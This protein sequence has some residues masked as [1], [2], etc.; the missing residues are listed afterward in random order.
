MLGAE[1]RSETGPN[2]QRP[3]A[4]SLA[5]HPAERDP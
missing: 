4:A 2:P 1:S 3:F 5:V